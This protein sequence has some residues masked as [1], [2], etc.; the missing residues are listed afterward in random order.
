MNKRS[1][2]IKNQLILIILVVTSLSTLLSFIF[3]FIY[4]YNR[5]RTELK[6]GMLFTLK[7]VSE[8]CKSPLLFNDTL[9]AHELLSSLSSIPL[10][11]KASVYDS[12]GQHFAGFTRKGQI[13]KP[14]IEIEKELRMSFDKTGL[15][16]SQPI[17][18]EK[19]LFGAFTMDIS[20]AAIKKKLQLSI[21]V[22]FLMFL[23]IMAVSFSLA[24][25]LQK[26]ISE[27]ILA[28]K[29]YAEQI[30]GTSDYSIRIPQTC[31]N[32][33]GQLQKSFD[34]MV[35]QLQDNVS[36][37]VTSRKEAL[38]LRSELKDIIDSLSS[39]IIAVDSECKV[40]QM[41]LEAKKF[42]G[43]DPDLTQNRPVTELV[44]IL[45]DKQD[46]FQKCREERLPQ[47][48]STVIN[49]PDRTGQVYLNI[50]IY[51]SAQGQNEGYVI[52][53]DDVSDKTKM[54]MML[55]QNEKMMSL[56]GLAAGMAHEINNPL[57]IISQS[58]LNI[59][60]HLLPD[61]KRNMEAAQ[62]TGVNLALVNQYLEKRK[63]FYYLEGILSASKRASGIVTNM[64][65]FSR[66]S[67]R[68]KSYSCIKEI[69]DQTVELAYNEYELKKK[70]D[71]R[72]IRII[73]EYDE[74][75]PLVMC[76]ATEI[77][78]VILN[79][80]KN[81]AHALYDK[82]DIPNSTI[83]LR[84]AND[85]NGVRVEVEDN[86]N[87]VPE[88]IKD[89][90]F[91]PF[92]TTKEVGVGTGLGL[93]VSYFIITKNHLGKIHF[94]STTGVGTKFIIHLP[95]NSEVKTKDTVSVL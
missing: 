50:T 57:G 71:F 10:V 70:F 7:L 18:Q 92:F 48:F 11:L 38:R 46:S 58:A 26:I 1:L 44:S 8:N 35:R 77:Q 65:Q 61:L 29:D 22:F 20:T 47:R 54:E 15:H 78:Q 32:E 75:I 56:G 12:K 23:I 64:L 55:I 21:S 41:N 94:E 95:V 53:I 51:P 66:M 69:I 49:R 36:S 72:Q 3:G 88:D 62:E 43:L 82:G 67:N 25:A 87:G 81:A 76:N 59:Q 13:T 33:I 73:R 68:S 17:L 60:R 91:E 2:S 85:K 14:S 83:T 16:L 30:K 42:L 93:S 80:L 34:L 5:S 40:R 45:S 37:L 90:I 63:I 19:E 24:N 74:K 28:L 39:A 84:V 89:R 9:G 4:D 6:N 86:A 27:P 31:Q 79:L 52:R